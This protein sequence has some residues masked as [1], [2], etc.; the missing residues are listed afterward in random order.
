[1]TYSG[2]GDSESWRALNGP[3][4]GTHWFN[5]H[6]DWIDRPDDEYLSIPWWWREAIKHPGQRIEAKFSNGSTF[7]TYDPERKQMLGGTY[8]CPRKWGHHLYMTCEVCGQYG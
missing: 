6:K 7:A 5:L 1:M 4:P 3:V 2:A 8:D